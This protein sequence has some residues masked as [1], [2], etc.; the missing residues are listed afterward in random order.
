[1]LLSQAMWA[2]AKGGVDDY[3]GGG[4]PSAVRRAL[5]MAFAALMVLFLVGAFFYGGDVAK[6]LGALGTS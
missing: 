6:Q 2:F 4:L 1:M 5:I 3:Q